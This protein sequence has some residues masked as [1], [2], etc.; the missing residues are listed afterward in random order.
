MKCDC[1]RC[2]R[3]V[4]QDDNQRVKWIC[5]YASEWKEKSNYWQY[6][7]HKL[8]VLRNQL[9]SITLITLNR[10]LNTEPI[11]ISCLSITFPTRT[12]QSVSSKNVVSSTSN[13]VLYPDIVT[14]GVMRVGVISIVVNRK[15]Y[16]FV[17]CSVY[18]KRLT[19][20]M[21]T[22]EHREIA[23]IQIMVLFKLNSADL[24]SKNLAK[25]SFSF[26][27]RCS[28]NFPLYWP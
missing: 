26:A 17:L 5:Y 21:N 4:L 15:I 8:Q 20:K 13:V 3:G 1:L 25:H 2:R 28:P 10:I 22:M 12:K 19:E 23:L 14:M 18:K 16:P 6:P 9:S 11:R 24:M 7:S 27:F